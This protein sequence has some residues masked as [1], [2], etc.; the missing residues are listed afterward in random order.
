MR[1]GLTRRLQATRRVWRR[2]DDYMALIPRSPT[3]LADEFPLPW[4]GIDTPP[5]GGVLPH[6]PAV[7]TGWALFESGAPVRVDMW[8]GDVALG[9]ARLGGYRPDVAAAYGFEGMITHFEHVIDVEALGVEGEATL[10]VVATGR[11]GETFELPG[12]VTFVAPAIERVPAPPRAPVVRGGDGLRLL[13]HTHRLNLGGAQLI[14]QDTLL[15]MHRQ[16]PFECVV[17][18]PT[19]GELRAPLEAAG[20]QVHI[21]GDLPADDYE[22][23]ASRIDEL[24]AW[25]A[26]GDFDAA[27]VNT[28]LAFPGADAARLA[29][30]PAVWAIRESYTPS[31]LWRVAFGALH[32]DIR[33]RAE[34]ALD[35]AAVALFEAEATRRLFLDAVG[36]ECL[37]RPYGL[38]LTALE[39]ERATIDVA[40][41]RAERGIPPSA[42]V[43]VAIGTAEPRK[44]QVPL[45]QAFG[46]IAERH[47]DALL[48]II[49]AREPGAK[50]LD[51]GYSDGLHAYAQGFPYANQVRVLPVTRDT[52][53]WYALA[54]L[55]V[56]ASDLE[57]LPRSVLE[58]MWWE[59]PVVATAIFGLPE[60]IEHGRTGWLCEPRDVGAL[61][62]ALDAAFGTPEAELRAVAAAARA[63]VVEH[64]DMERYASEC[65]ELLRAVCAPARS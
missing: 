33:R 2:N 38:D 52:T 1:D 24:A 60:L 63:H 16:S 20:F 25:T 10:R 42:K 9:P 44:A 47:P 6:G 19:D 57:S 65:A 64:H 13:V 27:F 51:D 8:L 37:T 53:P 48:V 50:G 45:V 62:G 34:G 3:A 56:C 29:G 55:M 30:V 35:A 61:A 46:L 5:A 54:D 14:L 41:A 31:M 23:Y 4:G 26:A 59:T 58:A 49:G 32:P 18:S 36:G 7:I 28:A 39:A 43:M 15:E 22:H 12:V 21:T 40:A 11:G 17:V